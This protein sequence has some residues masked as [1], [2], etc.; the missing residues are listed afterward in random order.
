MVKRYFNKIKKPFIVAEAGINHSGNI[1]TALKLVD[2][3]K[4]S[5]ADAIKFQTY[6]TE[7]RVGKINPK[8]SEIL[9]K[10]ELSYEDF[11]KINN[12]CKFK[13][14]TFF[15]TPFD[16]ESLDFLESIKVPF[17]KIASVDICNYQLVR[18][19]LK[20]NKPAIASTGMASFKEII[21]IDKMF[22]EKGSELVILHC[23]SSYPN[24]EKSS[25]L[26]NIPLLIKKFKR[27]IGIS[28]HTSQ[29][30]IP[31]Y[32]ALLGAKIIEKH[33]KLSN[34]HDCVDSPVS[35]TG[36]QLKELRDEVDKISL[37]LRKAKFGIRAEEINSKPFK[38]KKIF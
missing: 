22:K 1:K 23:V 29:I 5:G 36:I 26:S 2:M 13:K 18:K 10:C 7:Q 17:Y 16:E 35:I 28:D 25:Y 33:I 20:T 24:N 14:I 11:E 3:A 4:S 21:K 27:P 38:R 34:T 31:I 6:I 32:G 15:S 37:I 8:V 19:I 9:K 12:Y 30:K